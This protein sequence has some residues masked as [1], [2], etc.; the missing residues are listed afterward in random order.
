[1]GESIANLDKIRNANGS[2]PTAELRL[3]MQ[4]C[5][6]DHAAVYRTADSMAEGKVK[7]DEI[8]G[9]FAD[10]SIKDRSLIR[11]TDLVETLELQ[12]LLANAACTMH[13]AEA[14]KESRGAHA[15]E[16]FPDRDDENWMEHTVAYHADGKTTV[17]Y[18][19]THQHTLDDAEQ[20]SFP[21]VAR[22]Y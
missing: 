20:T 16:D 13:S 21:P 12:N 15:H 14:R 18:R 17:K 11:N 4:R 8:V 10:V 1:M 6:Q 19:P 5:M 2:T 3:K 7:I 9:E 22:V